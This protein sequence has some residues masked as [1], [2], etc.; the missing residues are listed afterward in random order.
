MTAELWSW[1]YYKLSKITSHPP[2]I[3]HQLNSFGC[4]LRKT[5]TLVKTF[6]LNV[7]TYVFSPPATNTWKKYLRNE[8]V[9]KF[10]NWVNDN[11]KKKPLKN[12]GQKI[13]YWKD[14]FFL[15]WIIDQLCGKH[16]LIII[17]GLLWLRKQCT[18]CSILK[19]FH[20]CLSRN[21]VTIISWYIK[22]KQ[23]AY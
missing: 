19:C 9:V 13:F 16:C 7:S 12:W 11:N 20:P 23:L 15:R 17:L 5:V 3:F 10:D 4:K 6:L 8:E 21:A 18:A 14:V 1:K 2:K 22:W